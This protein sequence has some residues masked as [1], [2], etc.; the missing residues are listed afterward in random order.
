VDFFEELGKSVDL[1][2]V[3]ERIYA[4]DREKIWHKLNFKNFKAYFLNGIR[5]GVDSS[6]SFKILKFINQDFDII[7]LGGYSTPTSILSELYLRIRK[8]PFIL[9]ADG[10]FIRENESKLKK[11]IKTWLISNANYWI[12]SGK[13]TKETLKYYGA[14]EDRIFT[15]PFTSIRQS[16][17]LSHIPTIEEKIE[18]RN[19]LGILEDKIVLSVGQFIYRKGFDILIKAT[20]KLDKNIGV[21]I[22]GGKPLKEYTELVEKLGLKDH[23]H[24]IEFKTKEEL[25]KYYIASD[26][27]VLPTREDIWGLVINEAMANALPIIT[28]N[29][30]IAGL[31]LVENGKN[32]F[33][34]H[35][36]SVEEIAEKISLIVNNQELLNDMS[37]NNILKIKEYTIEKMAQEHVNI[38]NKII[39][40]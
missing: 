29:K 8:I 9:N 20:S 32:G 30:C 11:K 4:K 23:I 17:I 18:L 13:F 37:K 12:C 15:Y 14:K 22:V 34:C 28:T 21:Y 16:D 24:F 10:A 6:L 19:K 33:I 36:D 7:V 27:F 2:V 39:K 26:I 40:K 1:T 3:F 25:K 35:I 38:F 31:E 5:A